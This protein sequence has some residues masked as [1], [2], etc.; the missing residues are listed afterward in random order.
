[1]GCIHRVHSTLIKKRGIRFT[2]RQKKHI[3]AK[4]Y[5]TYGTH[6]CEEIRNVNMTSAANSQRTFRMRQK[7]LIYI[8][9]IPWY[10]NEHSKFVHFLN[11]G[12]SN[13]K[14]NGY[15]HLNETEINRVL[16]GHTSSSRFP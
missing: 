14:F 6:I 8:S 10:I 15:V 7:D 11:T 9:D 12:S 3:T 13:C 2:K 16:R 4:D 5:E 1:M